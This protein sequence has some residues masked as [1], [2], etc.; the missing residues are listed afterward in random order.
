MFAPTF[1]QQQPLIYPTSPG[2]N[3]LDVLIGELLSVAQS[4]FTVFILRSASVQEKRGIKNVDKTLP[5]NG[6]LMEWATLLLQAAVTRGDAPRTAHQWK[7]AVLFVA[8]ALRNQGLRPEL[9]DELWFQANGHVLQFVLDRYVIISEEAKFFMAQ[10]PLPAFFTGL[11]CFASHFA[12]HA[13]CLGM[14]PTQYLLKAEELFL[15]RPF[16]ENGCKVFRKHGWTLY[17]NDRPDGVFIKTLH[18][19]AAYHPKH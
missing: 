13:V 3:D 15:Q 6:T 10:R 19:K 17:L 18:L 1:Y 5:L 11:L 2:Y 14:S 16:H 4:P 12:K 9:L 8:E 7:N